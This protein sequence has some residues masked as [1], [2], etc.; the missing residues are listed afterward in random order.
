MINTQIQNTKN[1]LIDTINNCGLSAAI[2]E[3]IL[4]NLLSEVEIATVKAIQEE[5][6]AANINTDF[7]DVEN[8]SDE[9]HD[10]IADEE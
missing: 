4:K 10:N 1:T 7:K 2:I 8:T 9:S 6:E 3:L 5:Q